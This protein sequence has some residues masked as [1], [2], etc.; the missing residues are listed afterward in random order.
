[1]FAESSLLGQQSVAGDRF[2][3]FAKTIQLTERGVDVRR[4]P[5]PLKFLVNDGGYEDVMFVEQILTNCLRVGSFDLDVG[6]GARLI[7]L[8][9]SVEANLGHIFEPVHPI[10]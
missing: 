8:E 10:A 2:Y 4:D 9:R 1:M 6:D 7:R 3:L 5:K